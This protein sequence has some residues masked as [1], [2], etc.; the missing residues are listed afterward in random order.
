MFDGS[1]EVVVMTGRDALADGVRAFMA[2]EA[3]LGRLRDADADA[4]HVQREAYWNRVR[5]LGVEPGGGLFI[6]AAPMNLLKLP[7]VA[8]LFPNARVLIAR[9]DP[10]DLALAAL[11]RHDRGLNA[12]GFELL[13]VEGAARFQAGVLQLAELYLDRL[14]LTAE[15]VR[16]EDLAAEPEAVAARIAG[17]AGVPADAGRIETPQDV[18]GWR[19]YAASFAPTASLLAPW[20]ERL[21]YPQD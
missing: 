3:G 7:L 17:F 13:T 20:V 15:I 18:G 19:D 2:D 1:D 4:L 8:R 9:R 16:Y 5:E 6:D 10:R 12:T 14:P 11:R 21:G